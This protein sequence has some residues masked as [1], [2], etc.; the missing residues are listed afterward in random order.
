MKLRFLSLSCGTAVCLA[1]LLAACSNSPLRAIANAVTP[2]RIDVL[3]GN[4]VSR[5]QAALLKP[6]MPRE[7]VRAILGSPLLTDIFHADRWDYVFSIRP[8][9]KP[10]QQRQLTVFFDA[11]GRL[12]RTEGD[13]LPSEEEFVAQLD[14]LRRGIVTAGDAPRSEPLAAAAAPASAAASATAPA[15]APAPAAATAPAPAPAATPA[16]A[17]A[18]APAA[19]AAP[20]AAQA[21]P[22]SGVKDAA[23]LEREITAMLEGWR[24]AWASRNVE[25]YLSYYVPEFKGEYGTRAA[26][27]A[28]RRQRIASTKF[29]RLD[30]LDVKILITDTDAARLA[31][32]Q[33]YKSDQHE[34]AGS[35]S[36]YLVKQGGKWLIDR[37]IFFSKQ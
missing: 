17:P 19:D 6:G 16:P 12:V 7:Q 11:Q 15:S 21:L 13:P 29:I 32:T 14:D 2:Y 24:N 35:K 30:L 34:E 23:A 25:Q 9:N 28:A 10:V 5:E 26:W 1:A 37:E 27:E 20:S 3:Q 31:F 8:G 36:L 33:S 18:P 22:A 4:F